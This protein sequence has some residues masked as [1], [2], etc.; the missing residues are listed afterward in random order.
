MLLA[1]AVSTIG[2]FARTSCPS[3]LELRMS[4]RPDRRCPLQGA[5]RLNQDAQFRLDLAHSKPLKLLKRMSVKPRDKRLKELEKPTPVR[6]AIRL[7]GKLGKLVYS[8]RN[9]VASFGAS[10]SKAER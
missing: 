1:T 4:N 7:A 9:A 3:A 10:V 5:S 2:R 8:A 6:S